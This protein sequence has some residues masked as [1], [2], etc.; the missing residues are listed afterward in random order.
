MLASEPLSPA[1]SCA[2]VA[3]SIDFGITATDKG[4]SHCQSAPTM[5]V[6]EPIRQTGGLYGSRRNLE[7]RPIS[8]FFGNSDTLF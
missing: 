5:I 8:P 3:S 4:I 1:G 6:G 2:N 7:L